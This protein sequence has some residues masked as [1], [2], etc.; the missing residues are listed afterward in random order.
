MKQPYSAPTAEQIPMDVHGHVMSAS[1]NSLGDYGGVDG[2]DDLGLTTSGT[3]AG[4]GNTDH[5]T[6]S[7]SDLEDLINDILTY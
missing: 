2:F 1:T 4:Y 6:A 5:R 3:A 7:G